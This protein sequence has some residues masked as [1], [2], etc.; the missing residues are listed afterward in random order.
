MSFENFFADMGHRP[1]G[2][3]LERI[4]NEGDYSPDNC[5]WASVRE[6]SQNRRN[7]HRLTH[8]GVTMSIAQWAA[9]LGISSG[10]IYQRFRKGLPIER[11]LDPN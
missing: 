7:V 10:S 3:T 8:K 2:K 5:K 1:S 4:D 9:R 6:Q 11:V